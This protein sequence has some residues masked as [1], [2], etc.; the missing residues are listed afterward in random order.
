MA[1]DLSQCVPFVT[2]GVLTF[3]SVFTAQYY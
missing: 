1:F 3:V 2:K